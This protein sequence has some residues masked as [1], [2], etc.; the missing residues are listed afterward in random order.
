MEEQIARAYLGLLVPMRAYCCC[1]II[2][3][4]RAN[5]NSNEV[6]IDSAAL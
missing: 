6:A 2:G 4:I 5:R 1:R 3:E